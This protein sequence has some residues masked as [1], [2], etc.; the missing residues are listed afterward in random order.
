MARFLKHLFNVEKL[1]YVKGEKP[2][3]ECVLCALEEGHSGVPNLEITRTGLF[4]VA[5]NLYPFNSGHLMIFPRRHIMYPDEFTE[6]EA[7]E[8]H[9]LL[10]KTLKIVKEEFR[11]S[12]FNV[13]YNLGQNSGASIRHL[14][15]HI[16]P[17]FPNEIGYLDVLAGTRTIVGDPKETMER[18]RKRF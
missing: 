3:V 15:Q 8:S 6:E 18:L 2:D 1:R 16:V 7:I 10:V 9:R 11:P 14:H 17:R 4:I 12:G 13:G 5:V